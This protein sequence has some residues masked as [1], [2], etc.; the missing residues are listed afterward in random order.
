M[1]ILLVE[2]DLYVLVHKVLRSIIEDSPAAIADAQ[3]S[4]MKKSDK[5]MQV[6]HHSTYFPIIIS[7]ALRNSM[8]CWKY[9]LDNFEHQ[10]IASQLRLRKML[11]TMRYV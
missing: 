5:K 8:T 1:Q 4:A 11:L 3:V 10:G 9:L 2:H 7:S 6:T